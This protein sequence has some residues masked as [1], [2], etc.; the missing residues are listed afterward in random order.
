MAT[1]LNQTDEHTTVADPRNEIASVRLRFAELK[2]EFSR[3]NI[4]QPLVFINWKRP[5]LTSDEIHRIRMGLSG[6]ATRHDMPLAEICQTVINELKTA[7]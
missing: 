2:V 3:M 4:K 7:A 1:P 6:R 5:T